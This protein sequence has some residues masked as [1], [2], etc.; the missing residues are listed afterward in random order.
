MTLDNPSENRIS[1]AVFADLGRAARQAARSDCRALLI[2]ADGED[3][4]W[5]GDFMEWPS[6]TT[7]IA[8]RERFGFSNGILQMIESLPFPTIAAVHG[9]AFGG[10]FEL[11][12]HA[13]L[14][15]ASESAR[16]R[17]SEATLGVAPLAGGIQRVAERAGRAVAARLVMLSEEMSAIEAARLNVVAKIVPDDKLEGEALALA[18]KLA[19]GPTRA[20]AVSKLVLS[21]WSTSGV[22]AADEVMISA[23]CD[24]LATRDAEAGVASAIEARKAVNRDQRSISAV[25][26]R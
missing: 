7:N 26:D 18:G 9:R 23:V 8:K 19:K 24:L 2:R 15:I 14:I 16:L 13:D 11:A 21:A 6:L 3:F 1:R 17:F 12:L 22:R 4:S 10:G 20:H 25:L 5:G